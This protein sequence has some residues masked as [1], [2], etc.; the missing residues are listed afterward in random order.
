V[1]ETGAPRWMPPSKSRHCHRPW[2]GP[3]MHANHLYWAPCPLFDAEIVG[4]DRFVAH[5]VVCAVARTWNP[6]RNRRKPRRSWT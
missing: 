5:F 3:P 6:L 4:R 2:V 1:Y